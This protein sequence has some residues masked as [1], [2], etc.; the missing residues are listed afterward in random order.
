MDEDKSKDGMNKMTGITSKEK[1]RCRKDKRSEE[2]IT[3]SDHQLTQWKNIYRAY[4]SHSWETSING[5][6]ECPADLVTSP[7]GSMA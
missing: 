1:E 4:T 5:S 2:Y 3:I 7:L 6:H